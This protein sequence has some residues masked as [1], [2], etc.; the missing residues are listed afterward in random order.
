MITD[1][2]NEIKATN[3]TETWDDFT[4]L[5]ILE[6]VLGNYEVHVCDC[7][8]VECDTCPHNFYKVDDQNN[9]CIP[10]LINEAWIKIV[11]SRIKA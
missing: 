1:R 6:K 9:A 7:E 3:Y 5:E 11:N 8:G 2:M 4:F 10:E